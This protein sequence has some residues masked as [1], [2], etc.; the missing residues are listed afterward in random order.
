[1]TITECKKQL[2]IIENNIVSNKANARSNTNTMYY[3]CM[4]GYYRFLGGKESVRKRVVKKG[5]TEHMPTEKAKYWYEEHADAY[6]TIAAMYFI[7]IKVQK[8]RQSE[9]E[10]KFRVACSE[11]ILHLIRELKRVFPDNIEKIDAASKPK[12]KQLF[13]INDKSY[14]NPM[15]IA[16]VIMTDILP[17]E[18]YQEV[19]CRDRN[20]IYDTCLSIYN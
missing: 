11:V 16:L 7:M 12:L 5:V 17:E 15:A 1:M 20:S 14:L 19:Y 9:I 8:A 2:E 10:S 3:Y 13:V 18:W 6:S 4:L